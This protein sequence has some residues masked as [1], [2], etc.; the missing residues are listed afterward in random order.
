MYYDKLFTWWTS[1]CYKSAK[2]VNLDAE[3]L[4][5]YISAIIGIVKS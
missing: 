3:I 4:I 5:K 1:K 2:V